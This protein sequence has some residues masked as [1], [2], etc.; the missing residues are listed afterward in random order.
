MIVMRFDDRAGRIE[1]GRRIEAVGCSGARRAAGA[2]AVLVIGFLSGCGSTKPSRYYQLT[3]VGAGAPTM[4]A[5]AFPVTLMVYPMMAPELYRA[6]PIVY[7]V[8]PEQMGVYAR[9]LW[10]APPPQMIQEVMVRELRSSGRY[11]NAYFMQSG[12]IADFGLRGH[13]YD[14]REVDSGGTL[15]ARLTM[16]VELRNPKTG[17]TVWTH[18]YSHDEPV[19]DKTVPAVVSALNKN[20]QMA[21]S[22]VAS[23]L[24]QYFASHPPK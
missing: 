4:S 15:V 10:V 16:D 24:D 3:P 11:Q 22:E 8:S 23:G 7:S 6:N 5:P 19:S 17:A 14:F 20:V 9:E 13:L 18:Y 12:A 2:F 21:V 1:P